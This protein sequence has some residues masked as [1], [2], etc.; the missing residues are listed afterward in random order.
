MDN[1]ALFR[2]SHINKGSG[3]RCCIHDTLMNMHLYM[4]AYVL[5]TGTLNLFKAVVLT[6]HVYTVW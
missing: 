2:G 4:H 1:V 3:R 6:V 5:Y